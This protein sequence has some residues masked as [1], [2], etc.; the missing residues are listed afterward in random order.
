MLRW[1]EKALVG[2]GGGALA[3]IAIVL[4]NRVLVGFG[5]SVKQHPE[6]G[7]VVLTVAAGIVGVI[8]GGI[9]FWA[10]DGRKH[11]KPPSSVQR[12]LGVSS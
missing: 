8:G 3:F 7:P 9:G 6:V 12:H 5:F 11:E 2:V 4:L 1:L 10:A